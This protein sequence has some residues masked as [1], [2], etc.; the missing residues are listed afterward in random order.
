MTLQVSTLNV[1]A[2]S[3]QPRAIKTD[4]NMA[5]TGY[6]AMMNKILSKQHGMN[7][8]IQLEQ[9]EHGMNI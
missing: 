1:L 5:I 2:S 8:M 9:Y 7:N 4:N 3:Q 6:L